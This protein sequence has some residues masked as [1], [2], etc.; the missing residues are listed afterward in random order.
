MIQLQSGDAEAPAATISA[1]SGAPL[2]PVERAAVL[3]LGPADADWSDVGLPI[4]LPLSRAIGRASR[5]A[6]GG[7]DAT[8]LT[9]AVYYEARSE[10]VEGEQAVAQVVMNRAHDHRYPGSVCGVVFQRAD[11]GRGTCQFTFACDGSMHGSI[12][13]GAW[14][15]ARSVAQQA[16]QGFVY[17][18]L[19]NAFHYHADY[20]A[21]A[22]SYELPRIRKIGRHIFYE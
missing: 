4:E 8:C 12:E 19:K 1:A 16:L 6:P 17:E 11:G 3:T 5:A 13:P 2:Q 7:D 21:P 18:P 22:W 20:V 10:G 9:Q 15:A 14:T